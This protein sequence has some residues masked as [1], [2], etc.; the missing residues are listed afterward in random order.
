MTY[1]SFDPLTIT[2]EQAL[3]LSANDK[4]AY[5]N[6]TCISHPRIESAMDEVQTMALPGS[7]ISIVFLIGPTGVGKTA[8]IRCLRKRYLKEYQSEIE[9]DPGFI[10]F[11]ALEA[12][13]SGERKFAW[14]EL[15]WEMGRVLCEPLMGQKQVT[16]REGGRIQVQNAARGSTVGAMSGAVRSA[17]RH[18]RTKLLVID[19]AVH[20]IRERL[21][22]SLAATM[23]ALKSI[24]N[25]DNLGNRVN[26]DHE[27]T[28]ALVGS[29]DLIPLMG[30]SGQLARR[31]GLVHFTPYQ[32][33]DEGTDKK[34]FRK[35][36]HTLQARLPL[37]NPPDL[38]KDS[39]DLHL[40]CLGCVGI[41]KETLARALNRALTAGKWEDSHLEDSLLD[42]GRL[43]LILGEILEGESL[44]KNFGH[45]ANSLASTREMYR[46]M[47]A[48]HRLAEQRSAEQ[49][50]S[51]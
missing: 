37:E 9:A 36:L 31:T 39:D 16:I 43:N 1:S 23:D 19:E 51:A 17:L 24:A 42:R 5:F 22:G 28:L 25:Q 45:G 27:L 10:P 2:R 12:P 11:A 38:V 21:G 33:E 46:A 6:A 4:R 30:L 20:M 26:S 29:Y 34:E 40:A 3:R 50:W 18:R 49:R 32:T 44:V 14:R 13:G 47:V 48:D 41:L 15:Y 35:T 8:L 7:G